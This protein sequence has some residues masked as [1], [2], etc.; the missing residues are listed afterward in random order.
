MYSRIINSKTNKIHNYFLNTNKEYKYLSFFRIFIG[1][2]ALYDL[3]TLVPDIDIFF[4]E[5]KTIIPQQLLYLF[6][7]YFE[8]LKPMYSFLVKNNL[9]SAFYGSILWI[10][11][12][13]IIFLILGFF[14]RLS[15]VVSI[16]LQLIIFKSFSMFN[17]GYDHF[18][19]SSLFYCLIFPVGKINSI[20]NLLFKRKNDLKVNF[21]YQN[22]IRIHLCFIYFFSG[23]A[24]IISASWWNGEA[25][26]KS[27]S[28]IYDDNFKLPP[29]LLLVAGIVT[30]LL[31]TLYPFIINF[32]KTR[33]TTVYLT[34]FMHLFIIFIL[35]LYTFGAI[36][37]VW[38]IA[39]YFDFFKKSSLVLYNVDA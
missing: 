26:W 32:N 22:I 33:K 9:L 12:S 38:N 3:F 19:T 31:E 25:I 30:I 7:E 34:I 39:A 35:K 36:M 28:T 24:K 20:D 4:S 27:I 17:F 10:Y 37:I 15:A 2:I 18:L 13:A 1:L 14:T 16:I 23:L 6:S 29:I 8:Y 11:I 5:K 21:N